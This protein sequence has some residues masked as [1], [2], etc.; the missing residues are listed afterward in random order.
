MAEDKK[1]NPFVPSGEFTRR[2]MAALGLEGEQITS[3][4]LTFDM[5]DLCRV[6]IKKHADLGQIEEVVRVLEYFNTDE[7]LVSPKPDLSG[8]LDELRG[9]EVVDTQI[10]RQP[11][12]TTCL[13]DKW[14]TYKNDNDVFLTV[15]LRGPV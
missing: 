1:C 4:H 10:S 3:I 13:S 12:E 15:Y 5:D 7:H 6:E 9:F 11:E 8:V 14:K 2:L